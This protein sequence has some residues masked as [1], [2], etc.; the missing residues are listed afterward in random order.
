MR[1]T[2]FWSR[3]EDALGAGYYRVWADQFVIAEL[4][5]RTASEALAAGVPPKEVWA[6]VWRV[7]GLPPRER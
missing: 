4:G 1:H 7:L 3:M 2:E 5:G 6:A